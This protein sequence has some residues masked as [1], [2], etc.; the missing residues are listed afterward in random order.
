MLSAEPFH[1][2]ILKEIF[3]TFI[4]LNSY[5]RSNFCISVPQYPVE[6][7]D[8]ANQFFNTFKFFLLLLLLASE[9]QNLA[10]AEKVFL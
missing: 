3:I 4:L 10:A 8:R 1:K 9:K 6:P 5:R 7:V 2:F